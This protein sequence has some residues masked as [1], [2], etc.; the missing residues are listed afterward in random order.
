MANWFAN[1]PVAP[2]GGDHLPT[3]P[4]RTAR[5]DFAGNQ[6]EPDR[7][8]PLEA[9]NAELPREASRVGKRGAGMAYPAFHSPFIG[10]HDDIYPTGTTATPAGKLA[11]EGHVDANELIGPGARQRLTGLLT[12]KVRIVP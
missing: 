3:D 12:R 9:E 2:V 6:V 5:Y 7:A 11:A 4:R 8:V 10:V 1:A